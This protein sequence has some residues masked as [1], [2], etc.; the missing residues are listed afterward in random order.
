MKV[1]EA[2]LVELDTER[3]DALGQLV[4][5]LQLGRLKVITAI[6]KIERRDQ[7]G[8]WKKRDDARPTCA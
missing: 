2:V 3:K 5:P 8:K 4:L 1:E 7:W 6:A